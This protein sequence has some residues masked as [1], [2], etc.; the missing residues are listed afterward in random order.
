VGFASDFYMDHRCPHL[1]LAPHWVGD[2]DP[3][4]MV[5]VR[6]IDALRLRRQGDIEAVDSSLAVWQFERERRSLARAIRDFVCRREVGGFEGYRSSDRELASWLAEGIRRGDFVAL[7]RRRA[8]SA[9]ETDTTLAER[10]LLREIAGTTR[11]QLSTGGR[12]YRLVAG[13]DLPGTPDRDR[14]E[15]VRREEAVRALGAIGAEQGSRGDLPGLLERAAAML[16]PDWRPPLAPKGLVLL[17]EIAVPRV[18]ASQPAAAITPSQMRALMESEKPLS[19]FARFVDEHGEPVSG[20]TGD[21]EHGDDPK[22]DLAFSGP[23]FACSAEVKGPRQAW[24]T[25]SEKTS[26]DLAG[27]L[28]QRWQE[29]RGEPDDKWKE[30][31]ERLVEVLFQDGKLPELQLEAEKKHTFVL[32]PPVALARLHGMYF[33]TNKCFLLPTAMASM[34]R[35]VEVYGENRHSDLLLVGHTDTSGRDEYNETLSLERAQSMAAFLTNDVARWLAYYDEGIAKEKRWGAL[36]DGDMLQALAAR[37][38]IDQGG[39]PVEAY[40]TRHNQLP[41]ADRA[42][43]WEELEVDGVLGPKT[44]AQLV[45]DYM[46]CQGTTL[47][48]DV[49]LTVHGC[50]EYFPLAPEGDDLEASPEDGVRDQDDRRVELFFFA[51]PFGILPVPPGQTSARGSEEYPEW[52]RRARLLKLLPVGETATLRVR[53]L[54]PGGEPYRDLR[55][56]AYAGDVLLASR[57]IPEDGIIELRVPADAEQATISVYFP[58]AESPDQA[59][60]RLD[61]TFAIR[62]E[63]MTEST[64]DKAQRLVNLGFAG[65]LPPGE[66]V[67]DDMRLALAD[68]QSATGESSG[69]GPDEGALLAQVVADHDAR[70]SSGD[71]SPSGSST[72]MA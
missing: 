67:T 39:S 22:C 70:E 50:G 32:R 65:D 68:Y 10:R 31:E 59:E 1:S 20:F 8:A 42:A 56:V 29:I 54:D 18:V 62:S 35:L 47:P 14:Y 34:Q 7:R 41:E 37:W 36:E 45:G 69:G 49:S 55:F 51:R 72:G 4:C 58:D 23:G 13:A 15:V 48:D 16:S 21:F 19:F 44:R 2:D 66:E 11:G 40:Q 12:R 63:P 30:Q 60:P 52:R 43:N 3:R 6:T 64:R 5:L 26:Q 71:D 27:E 33:D 61:W 17:R 25:F 28:T 46:N 24:L 53:L 38:Q 9:T 57:T